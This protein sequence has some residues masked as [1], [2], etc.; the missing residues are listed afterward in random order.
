MKEIVFK[1][2][3]IGDLIAVQP[4]DPKP[5]RILL[6]DW[7]RT[8]RGK[9]LAIGPGAPLPDGSGIAPMECQ[10]GDYVVFGAATGMETSY[11]GEMIRIMKDTD[12]DAV[13]EGPSCS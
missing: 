10:V 11:C 5:T 3:L 9:V 1:Q 13:V 2:Q 4:M 8:L 7:Q 12:P 6:P